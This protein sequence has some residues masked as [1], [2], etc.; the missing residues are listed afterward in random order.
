MRLIEGISEGIEGI[1]SNKFRVA[2]ATISIVIGV[3]A[4]IIVVA[5]GEICKKQISKE[6]ETFG[7]N[8]VWIVRDWRD[9]KASYEDFSSSSNEISNRDIDSI[10]R[11]SSYL[12]RLSPCAMITGVVQCER[13]TQT[14]IILGTTPEHEQVAREEVIIGRFLTNFDL[15]YHH[16]V[17]VLSSKTKEEL[18]GKSN[19]VGINIYIRGE[20]FK[21]IGVLRKKER[22]FLTMIRSISSQEEG[23]YIPLSILQQWLKTKNIH[24]IY[25]EAFPHTSK[26]LANEILRLLYKRHC[27]SIEFKSENM[28]EYVK[29]A[30][31]IIGILTIVLGIIATISLFVAG[32]GIM[33][34]MVT[35]VVERT[36]EIGIRKSVGATNMDI[37]LQFLIESVIISLIGGIIGTFIGILGVGLIELIMKLHGLIL[38]ETIIIAL[39][40]SFIVGVSSGFYPAKRAAN[41]IPTEALRYE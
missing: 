37:Y 10:K 15:I 17:C 29:T 30:N 4:V 5:I 38:W 9:R 6:L 21:V 36:R 28:E 24:Y 22:G 26:Y 33:N 41:L 12:V 23:I 18:F 11:I 8:S 34:I 2:M 31:R 39:I 20:K 13:K 35:S 14:F 7:I 16:K 3:C 1:K 25:A 27:S 19:P 32:V 40:I